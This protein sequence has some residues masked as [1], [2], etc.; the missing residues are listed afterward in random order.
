MYDR[1]DPANKLVHADNLL[2][3]FLRELKHLQDVQ[4]KK[5]V[6]GFEREKN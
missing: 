1:V 5:V 6:P 3:V 2:Q 4:T